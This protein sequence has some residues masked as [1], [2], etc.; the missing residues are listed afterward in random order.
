[1]RD[2]RVGRR[3]SMFC[4][5]ASRTCER[6]KERK[7]RKILTVRAKQGKKK[8]R[9][10]L[11]ITFLP[12]F[13]FSIPFSSSLSFVVR[14]CLAR[15]GRAG[16]RW[17]RGLL[18]AARWRTQQP[19]G[20]SSGGSRAT[21][22]AASPAFDD[23]LPTPAAATAPG[24][25]PASAPT[26]WQGSA[27]PAARGS[28]LPGGRRA[29]RAVQRAGEERRGG[30]CCCRPAV[31]EVEDDDE[32][33][34]AAAAA[35]GPSSCCRSSCSGSS[36]SP[37]LGQ[38]ADAAR[39]DG[40]RARRPGGELV[41]ERERDERE[42]EEK[43]REREREK[44]DETTIQRRG[45][46][47]LLS[48]LFP[49]P[50]PTKTNRLVLPRPEGIRCLLVSGRGKT[51]AR[52]RNGAVLHEFASL[53]P[54]GGGSG[55]GGGRSG[56]AAAALTEGSCVLDAIFQPDQ[57][58]SSPGG[59]DLLRARRAGVGRAR[60]P[61]C[62][63]A[64]GC[65]SGCRPSSPRR[66]AVAPPPAP[67]PGP[68]VA[69]VVPPAAAGASPEGILAAVA[70][71]GSGSSGS[72][73][74]SPQDPALSATAC[75]SSTG[76]RA[77]PAT[78]PLPWRWSG[79]TLAARG[80]WWRR[81]RGGWP[82]RGR[83]RCC[84][85]AEVRDEGGEEGARARGDG[86][87]PA[88]APRARP[89]SPW[90][91]LLPPLR[92]SNSSLSGPGG[93]SGSPWAPR[94]SPLEGARRFT[95]PTTPSFPPPSVSAGPGV[96]RRRSPPRATACAAPGEGPTRCRS[97]CSSTPRGTGCCRRWR[98]CWRRRG[99]VVALAGV[100]RRRGGGD[101]SRLKLLFPSLENC[102]RTFC[103]IR[104]GASLAK[105]TTGR[106]WEDAGRAP[107]REEEAK[108]KSV[109]RDFFLL[110]LKTLHLFFFFD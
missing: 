73:G 94:A 28:R 18:R 90:S 13:C 74:G 78:R 27:R 54:G 57:S 68:G 38:A 63:A 71:G 41:S 37:L 15:V 87:R 106:R 51:V 22:A 60:P 101:E 35:A 110:R 16:W 21:A 108:K 58:S 102:N 95:T 93:C 40:R 49:L 91:R 39:V 107:A 86:G 76:N 56:A 79:R 85:V 55:S 29:E 17:T 36:P 1:M 31:E 98:R 44:R 52:G 64:S 77:T 75:C 62:D 104:E 19:C 65:L 34:G 47:L 103:N 82:W 5:G 80:T 99:G 2:V 53:L 72:G 42:R 92:R 109:N 61:G 30:R 20:R 6:E 14:L 7:A 43:E 67:A 89:R 26:R 96:R 32:G 24:S 9:G 45:S 105:R 84:R 83:A 48:F 12:V 25:T 70:G 66:A 8:Q 4:Y 100:R 59:R 88:G 50:G 23:E 81:T 11:L 46:T 33:R 69:R 97:C 3:D 10:F